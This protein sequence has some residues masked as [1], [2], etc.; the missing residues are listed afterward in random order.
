TDLEDDH[1]LAAAA[2]NADIVHR[3]ADNH[4]AIGH[5]HN[6]VVVPY[7]EYRNDRI[8]A[9][10]QVHIVDPLPAAPGDPVVVRGG[11]DPVALFR[12]AQHEFLALRQIGIGLLR[13]RGFLATVFIVGF[14]RRFR[15]SFALVAILAPALGSHFQISVPGLGGHFLVAQ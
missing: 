4:S 7:R 5:Q 1:A 9:P 10:G 15:R 13:D 2:R 12:D 3:A 8:A 14:G 11:P 6:L